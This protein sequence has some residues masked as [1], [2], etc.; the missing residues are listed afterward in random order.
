MTLYLEVFNLKGCFDVYQFEIYKV[1]TYNDPCIIKEVDLLATFGLINTKH[2]NLPMC[3]FLFL[4]VV[5]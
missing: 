5:A 3:S 4:D 2:P 1:K